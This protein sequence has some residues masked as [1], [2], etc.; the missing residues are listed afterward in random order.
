MLIFLRILQV[1]FFIWF[2][3]VLFTNNPTSI[4]KKLSEDGK[5]VDSV[6][7]AFI[8][9]GLVS[10]SLAVMFLALTIMSFQFK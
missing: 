3:T 2:L 5:Q 7:K 10:I 6:I 8:S 4:L 1:I 9:I